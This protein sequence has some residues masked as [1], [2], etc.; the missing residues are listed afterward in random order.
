MNLNKKIGK[1]LSYNENLSNLVLNLPRLYKLGT[2]KA[3]ILIELAKSHYSSDNGQV[4]SLVL[5]QIGYRYPSRI[6][7]MREDGWI[8]TTTQKGFQEH[9]YELDLDQS[10]VLLFLM[11]NQ[12]FREGWQKFKKRKVTK[13][14]Y[15]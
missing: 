10:S 11:K 12:I 1:E 9:Y 6:N 3:K 4:R 13:N 5:N 2:Q 7:E 14:A 15:N 8:I